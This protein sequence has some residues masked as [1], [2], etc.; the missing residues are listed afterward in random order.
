M[1]MSIVGGIFFGPS[2]VLSAD[3]PWRCSICGFE[4][5]PFHEGL[6]F[7]FNL[8]LRARHR[9]LQEGDTR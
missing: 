9:E 5:E 6:E 7:R 2:V 4:F 8:H 1:L 3:G